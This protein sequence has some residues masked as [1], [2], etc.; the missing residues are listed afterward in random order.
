MNGCVLFNLKYTKH[1]TYIAPHPL[2]SHHT[3]PQNHKQK[4]PTHPLTHKNNTKST[5]QNQTQWAYGQRAQ[6][7][8]SRLVDYFAVVG[9]DEKSGVK[10]LNPEVNLYIYILCI[11]VYICSW[12]ID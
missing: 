12:L 3:T 7:P 4:T 5:K 1:G 11:C 9:L 2:H 6:Q 8:P 10:L